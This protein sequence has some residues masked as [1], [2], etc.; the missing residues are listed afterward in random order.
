MKYG[1]IYDQQTKTKPIKATHTHMYLYMCKTI[2]MS[3]TQKK[4]WGGGYCTNISN[5]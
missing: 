4:N 1:A 5:I 3:N 2:Y